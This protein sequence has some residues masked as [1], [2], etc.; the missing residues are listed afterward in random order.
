VGSESSMVLDAR[1]RKC[2]RELRLNGKKYNKL[3]RNKDGSYAR[4]Q[5]RIDVYC[6]EPNK[7][8]EINR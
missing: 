7:T 4:C 6:P 1:A 5:Q 2:F 3:G 8:A